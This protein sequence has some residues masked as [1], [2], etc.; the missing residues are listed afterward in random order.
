[1]AINK[2]IRFGGG[3]RA[4]LRLEIINLFDNPWYAAMSSVA[5][6]NTNFGKVESQGNYSRT[7]QI[8]GDSRSRS[9]SCS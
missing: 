8:T 9:C 7:M 5:Y 6:G 3:K 4:T 2:D 1:M